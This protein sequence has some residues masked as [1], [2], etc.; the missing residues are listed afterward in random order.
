VR[1]DR[2]LVAVAG[3]STLQPGV[4]DDAVVVSVKPLLL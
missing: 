3:G 2:G 4:G 1:E